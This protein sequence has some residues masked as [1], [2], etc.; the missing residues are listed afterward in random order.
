[1]PS[2]EAMTPRAPRQRTAL[3]LAVATALLLTACGTDTRGGSSADA[4]ASSLYDVTSETVDGETWDGADLRGRVTVLWFWAPWCPTCRAQ[5][6]GINALSAEHGDDVAIVGVGAQD[7][8]QAIAEFAAAVDPA[9]T[10]LSDVDGG[11][12]RHFEV[13]AQSTYLVLDDTGATQ[14]EGYLDEAELASIVADLVG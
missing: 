2:L 12:W 3:A 10:S 5:I 8:A 7:D 1:M 13:T 6:S 9:V 4:S 14:A 11:V